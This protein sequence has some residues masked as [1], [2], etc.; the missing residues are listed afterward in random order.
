VTSL[1]QHFRKAQGFSSAALAD[2]QERSLEQHS[3]KTRPL[4]RS[5]LATL[6]EGGA[7][8]RNE[9]GSG[10]HLIGQSSYSGGVMSTEWMKEADRSVDGFL[11]LANK[12][13]IK[14]KGKKHGC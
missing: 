8:P 1:F 14:M 5:F 4:T 6:T 2:G 7:N 11:N 12:H 10:L 13:Y 3:T 9:A